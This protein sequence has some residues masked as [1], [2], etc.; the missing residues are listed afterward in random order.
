MLKQPMAHSYWQEEI[1]K[2]IIHVRL[3]NRKNLI[4][5]CSVQKHYFLLQNAGNAFKEAQISKFRGD[6]P[7]DPPRN[8][9][10]CQKTWL[11]DLYVTINLHCFA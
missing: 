10:L 1:N 3:L 4:C 5:Q 11:S 6:M 9:C 8:S 2:K 7:S